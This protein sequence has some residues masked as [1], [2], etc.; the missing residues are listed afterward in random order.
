MKVL[1][2]DTAL[3]ARAIADRIYPKCTESEVGT[4]HSLL[5]RLEQK[6]LVNRD[7][8]L[9]V[10][11][12]SAAVSREEVAGEALETLAAKIADGSMAPFILHLV[13]SQRLSSEEA[14]EIRRM[15]RRYQAE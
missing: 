14:A 15:L 13:K 4:V 7:R 1:W 11:L 5:Q 12:F 8:T 9:H 10:H 3:P 6:G 2:Q